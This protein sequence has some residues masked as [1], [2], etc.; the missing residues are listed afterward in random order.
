MRR[1]HYLLVLILLVSTGSFAQEYIGDTRAEVKKK[2]RQTIKKN[3][4]LQLLETDSTLELVSTDK[5]RQGV[6]RSFDFDKAAV[7]RSEKII[8]GCEPCLQL[9]LNTVLSIK[10][11]GWRK[12]NENQY[13]S[14]Y[15][16]FLMLELA[17]GKNN[18][19]FTILKTN[20]TRELYRLLTGQ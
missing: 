6:D 13:V 20:W 8:S 10:K 2:L 12:V 4:P 15:D 16:K 19:S 11:Y 18:F 9:Q 14:V 17:P 5:T 7:C 1:S 3:K